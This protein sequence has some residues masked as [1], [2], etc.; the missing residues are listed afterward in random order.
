M[1]SKEV[2]WDYDRELMEELNHFLKKINE[3][4][5]WALGLSPTY[6][7][8]DMHGEEIPALHSDV[9]YFHPMITLDDRMRYIAEHIVQSSHSQY[10]IVCNTLISHFYGAR[11]IHNVL[12]WE[13]DDP[14]KAMVDFERIDAGDL[15]YLHEMRER[16]EAA[17]EGGLRIWESTAL[18]TSLQTAAKRYVAAQEGEDP[19]TRK[20]HPFDVAQWVASFIGDGT[21]DRLLNARTGAQGY[22]VLTAQP[23]IGSYYGYH[24]CTSNSVNPA[25]QFTH[26][27]PFIVPG[28]GARAMVKRMWGGRIPDKHSGL[29]IQ[30]VREHQDEIGVTDGV[31]FHPETWNIVRADG[32]KIYKED[33][34][35]L[36]YYGT[37]VFCCQFEV[38][39]NL[40]ANPKLAK[41][42]G[43]VRPEP[44]PYK[45]EDRPKKLV[46]A[47][48][49]VFG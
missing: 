6:E 49:E 40:K 21:I 35:E 42:R 46:E 11:N 34:N 36:K 45:F 14:A 27:D 26:D 15:D 17:I 22:D 10:N 9:E 2:L 8:V 37:E 41:K 19:K 48:D 18:H 12:T 44:L 33:Q 5:L 43:I 4:S 7:G 24:G 20:M 29:A 31:D 47:T 38:F 1:V 32:T 3:R 16:V 23:G 25:I 13:W 30:F 28:P 39:Q